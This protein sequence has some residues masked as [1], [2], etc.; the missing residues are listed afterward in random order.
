MFNLI[1][2]IIIGGIIGW[3]VPQPAWSVPYVNKIVEFVK[4]FK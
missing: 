1:L 4:N 3:T 2:G